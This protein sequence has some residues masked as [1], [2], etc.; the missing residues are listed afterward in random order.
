[1][2]IE[3]IMKRKVIIIEKTKAG[4]SL[5]TTTKIIITVII[6]AIS[7]YHLTVTKIFLNLS[8]QSYV[9]RSVYL[10]TTTIMN[11]KTKVISQKNYTNKNA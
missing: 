3:A 2:R 4:G 11:T 5:A 9:N 8:Q 10:I 7:P 1:M 6:I